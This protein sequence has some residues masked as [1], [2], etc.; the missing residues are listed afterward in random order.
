MLPASIVELF[1]RLRKGL[2]DE[3]PDGNDSPLPPG[4]EGWFPSRLVLG[5]S[6]SSAPTDP[7]V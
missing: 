2:R 3:C 5:Q 4:R 1:L 7:E 6:V